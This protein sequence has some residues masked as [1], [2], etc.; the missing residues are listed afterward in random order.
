MKWSSAV[1]ERT[2]LSEAVEECVL[3]VRED[4]GGD[5]PNQDTD[6]FRES[7]GPLPLSG[8]FCNGEIGQVGESTYLTAT[9]APSA[10][11]GPKAGSGGRPARWGLLA[12]ARGPG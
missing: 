4:L 1:S 10:S 9:P 12:R 7:V 2:S 3:K 8:F 5:R 6:L 11:P